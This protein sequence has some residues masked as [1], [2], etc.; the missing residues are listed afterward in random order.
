MAQQNRTCKSLP[1]DLLVGAFITAYKSS[2]GKVMFSQA[3]VKNSVQKAD[4]R[5]DTPTPGSYSYPALQD[6]VNNRAVRILLECFLVVF[7]VYW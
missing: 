6:T 5:A 4:S 1:N 3:G 2:C 7:S